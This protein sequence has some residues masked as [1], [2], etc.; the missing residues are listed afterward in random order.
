MI[1]KEFNKKLVLILLLFF[2]ILNSGCTG[3]KY[4]S[5]VF[6]FPQVHEYPLESDWEYL[7]K[8]Y[9]ID[10]PLYNGKKKIK[11]FLRDENGNVLLKDNKNVYGKDLLP[12]VSWDKK[13][14]VTI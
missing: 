2:Y 6:V 13:D 1:K 7:L 3:R 11:L 4:V 9:V 8:I 10:K 12:H 5:Y 14:T